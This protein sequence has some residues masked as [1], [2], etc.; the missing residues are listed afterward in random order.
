MGEPEMRRLTA[1][2]ARRLLLGRRIEATSVVA[3]TESTAAGLALKLSGG[4][5][6]IIAAADSREGDPAAVL[7]FEELTDETFFDGAARAAA[8]FCQALAGTE[9]QAVQVLGSN[10][11][12]LAYYLAIN[13]G[14]P[15]QL[16]IEADTD[17]ENEIPGMVFFRAVEPDS[18]PHEIAAPV[19]LF[20]NDT[21]QLLRDGAEPIAAADPDDQPLSE[22]PNARR[23]AEAQ[24]LR[25]LPHL[26]HACLRWPD[27]HLAIQQVINLINE[28]RAEE[29]EP[30]LEKW[31][32][33]IERD[34]AVVAQFGYRFVV[35]DDDTGEWVGSDEGL[36]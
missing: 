31:H 35:W 17:E 23:L 12:M 32:L 4:E 14:P 33:G 7:R 18:E 24:I 13:P 22:D 5:R 6:L 20:D 11:T 1:R 8:E 10:T 25:G 19:D 21:G 34:P 9:V 2:Q 36:M 27:Y 26:A 28:D 15:R 30:L 16:T 29:A 3:A